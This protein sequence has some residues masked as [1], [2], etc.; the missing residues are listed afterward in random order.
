MLG[1]EQDNS[2]SNEFNED[3]LHVRLVELYNL[4]ADVLEKYV[5]EET[6]EVNFEAL[7]SSFDGNIL[8]RRKEEDGGDVLSS[9]DNVEAKSSPS[10]V[11][12]NLHN[13]NI[14]RIKKLPTSQLKYVLRNTH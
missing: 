9:H 4:E 1:G 11:K 6:V 2:L 13:K 8:L 3:E 12:E 5:V 7:S 14:L 10:L